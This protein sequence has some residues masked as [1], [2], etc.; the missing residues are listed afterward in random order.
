MFSGCK[1][2]TYK[3]RID[4]TVDVCASGVHCF[5]SGSDLCAR[6][7]CVPLRPFEMTITDNAQREVSGVVAE[8]CVMESPPQVYFC[9]FAS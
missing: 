3:N 2:C 9:S 8:G 6:Q 5:P 4:D 1:R 7:N